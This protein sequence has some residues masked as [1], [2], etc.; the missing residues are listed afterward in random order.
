MHYRIVS[1]GEECKEAKG[2][3]TN[4]SIINRRLRNTHSV[5]FVSNLLKPFNSSTIFYNLSL[6]WLCKSRFYI[7]SK[8]ISDEVIW[9]G[10]FRHT[11]ICKRVAGTSVKEYF[12]ESFFTAE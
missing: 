3:C 1:A 10:I 11:T 8:Y 4:T 5:L 2:N 7:C 12:Q 6:T 9:I